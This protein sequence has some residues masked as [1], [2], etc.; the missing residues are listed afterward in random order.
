MTQLSVLVVDDEP[1]A[2]RRLTTILRQLP[3]VRLAGEAEDGDEAVALIRTLK[4]DVVLLDV[5]MPGL[6]GFDV[7]EALRGPGAPVVIF[8]TAFNHYAVQAFEVSAVDYVLK[9]VAFDRLAA[10]LEKARSVLETGDIAARLAEVETV[11][12]AIR[13]SEA[14][15]EAGPTYEREIWVQKRAEF[16]RVP[17]T[18]ID[19]IE[20]ERD[21]VRLHAAGDSYLLRE[22]ISRMEERLDPAD[23]VR[24]HRS[25]LVRRERIVAVQQAGYGAIRVQLAT[26][27]A[28]RVGRTYVARVRD[29]MRT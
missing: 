25:A 3:G 19:W 22:P 29:I 6:N 2:R 26:G 5:K 4:P 13:G 24:I 18:Q 16:R 7:L 1:L 12:A 28:V 8:V 14:Q 10:A 27:I 17:V 9:P 20:A 11:L 23:F 21:Y 15:T